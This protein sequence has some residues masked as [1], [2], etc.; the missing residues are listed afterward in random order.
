MSLAT[1]KPT[2]C[3]ACAETEFAATP[4]IGT[5]LM[6]GQEGEFAVFS[7]EACGS[8]TT[9]PFVAEEDLGKLYEGVYAPFSD[10]TFPR[11]LGW[12]LKLVRKV[13]DEFFHRRTLAAELRGESGT[14]LEVGCGT[15][16]FGATFIE[17]GWDVTGIEPSPIAAE[18]ARHRGM[19]I[20]EGTLGTYPKTGEQFD[21]ILF[22]NSLEHTVFPRQELEEVAKLLRPGGKLLVEVPNFGCWQVRAFKQ[23][24]FGLSLPMHR[25]HFTP[26]GLQIAMTDAGLKVTKSTATTG[27]LSVPASLEYKIFGRWLHRSQLSN[28]ALTLASMIALPVTWTLDKVLGGGDALRVV[29]TNPEGSNKS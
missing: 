7:C 13:V 22:R 29:A 20:H 16:R 15:G 23:N 19:K 2:R 14:L 12:A 25:T 8:G 10:Y 18:H 1:E 27:A 11:G 21:A 26:K 3:S 5:D 17:R 4:I 28:M 24:F 6:M 9:M